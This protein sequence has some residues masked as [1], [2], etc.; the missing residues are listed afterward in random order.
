MKTP[1]AITLIIV[2]GLLILAPV[3][4]AERQKERAAAF[5]KEHSNNTILPDAMEPYGPY[6]WACFAAGV[7]LALVGVREF[8]RRS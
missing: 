7:V 3:F 5:Y 4:S 1:I 6:D 8:V 2:G